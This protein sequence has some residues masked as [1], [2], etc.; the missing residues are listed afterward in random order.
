MTVMIPE[1]VYWLDGGF[2]LFPVT[3]SKLLKYG[4]TLDD[5]SVSKPPKYGTTCEW[6]TD[7]PNQWW[8]TSRPNQS[9]TVG[10]GRIL[11]QENS[12]C[13]L[14]SSLGGSMPFLRGLLFG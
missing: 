11:E 10:Q 14:C 2:Y 7:L 12:S 6:Y 5:V 4:L 3:S 13:S 1:D 8:Y 9:G